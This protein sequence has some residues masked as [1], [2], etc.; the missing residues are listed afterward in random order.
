VAE[1]TYVAGH[2]Y[3]NPN[4]GYH[5]SCKDATV[6]Q[7]TS[8]E[9]AL[10]LASAA[11]DLGANVSGFPAC[12]FKACEAYA[13]AHLSG[14]PATCYASKACGSMDC[15]HGYEVK[16]KQHFCKYAAKDRY[17]NCKSECNNAASGHDDWVNDCKHGCGYWQSGD[18]S[19][20]NAKGDWVAR[21]T[22]Q[23]QTEYSIQHGT[24]KKHAESKTKE[25]SQS[26]TTTVTAKFEFGSASVSN[27]IGHKT[28]DSY[29][30]EWSSN[31]LSSYQVTFKDKDDGKQ[32]WQYVIKIEDDCT[33]TEQTFT[34]DYAL[35]AGKWQKPCCPP[36]YG[37]QGHTTDYQ[38]CHSPANKAKWCSSDA[39]YFTLV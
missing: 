29:S 6:D 32:L 20:T 11:T 7:N 37:G 16:D 31:S 10:V 24:S 34:R 14:Y 23:G 13:G 2:C 4:K 5:F 21:E 26:V 25:W 22:I 12:D 1:T 15:S 33:H 17:S 18:C 39:E 19:A 3:T 36:G 9:S 28:A 35:T 30:N 38:S 8:A 27:E